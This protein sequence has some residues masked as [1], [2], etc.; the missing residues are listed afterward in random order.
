MEEHLDSSYLTQEQYRDWVDTNPPNKRSA[1]Y[2]EWRKINKSDHLKQNFLKW[3]EEQRQQSIKFLTLLAP[4]ET[5]EMYYQDLSRLVDKHPNIDW[6]SLTD[7]K[8]AH[9]LMEVTGS[10]SRDFLDE[11]DMLMTFQEKDKSSLAIFGT[12][13]LILR[14]LYGEKVMIEVIRKWRKNTVT[15][16]LHFLGKIARNWDDLKD[17]PTDWSINLVE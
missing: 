5:L 7:L 6:F 14:V 17:Y 4:V 12:Y 3:P 13:P 16:K 11:A 10:L 15:T 9:A 1:L 2:L 8:L